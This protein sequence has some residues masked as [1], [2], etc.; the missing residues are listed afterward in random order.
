MIKGM[1]DTVPCLRVTD[2]KVLGCCSN[3]AGKMGFSL[4]KMG[5]SFSFHLP[6]FPPRQGSAAEG[7]E[8]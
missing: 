2:G 6:I 3:K 7:D 1:M 5:F 8:Q 4:G